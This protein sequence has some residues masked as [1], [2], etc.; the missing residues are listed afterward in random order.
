M[1]APQPARRTDDGFA[2]CSA[3]GCHRR[4]SAF[5]PLSS[6]RSRPERFFVSS[7]VSLNGVLD[8]NRV[9]I[10][11]EPRPF[12]FFEEDYIVGRV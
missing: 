6:I 1:S 4:G 12:E 7:A 9:R 5:A 2:F 11:I 8:A 3:E 10:E